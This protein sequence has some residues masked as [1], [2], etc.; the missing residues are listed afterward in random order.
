M[1]DEFRLSY[2]F[3]SRSSWKISLIKPN[4]KQLYSCVVNSTC[5]NSIGSFSCE[6]LEGYHGD[7]RQ[8]CDDV[9]ECN[10]RQGACVGTNE[11]CSNL[12]GSFECVCDRGY[13]RV[14]LNGTYSCVNVN[15]C[16]LGRGDCNR[17]TEV[18]VDVQG[19]FRC[20]LVFFMICTL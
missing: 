6:C 15:E 11:V 13:D 7:G 1:Q 16:E 20:E 18:C 17:T 2:Y 19:G 14:E 8:Q 3:K 12:P 10:D 5:K 4:I 9:D